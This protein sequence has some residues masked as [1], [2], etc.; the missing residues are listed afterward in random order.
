MKRVTLCKVVKGS[1]MLDLIKHL[2]LYYKRAARSEPKGWVVF[3]NTLKELNIPLSSVKNLKLASN[4]ANCD[5][6]RIKEKNFFLPKMEHPV[7]ERGG[8]EEEE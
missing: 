1:H 3:L 5:Q 8:G 4:T 2:S 6:T 7:A